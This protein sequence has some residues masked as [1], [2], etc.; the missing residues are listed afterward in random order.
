MNKSRIVNSNKS[1]SQPKYI[2]E[3]SKY[4]INIDKFD[5]KLSFEAENGLF[6]YVY[7]Y[8]LFLPTKFEMDTSF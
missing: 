1:Q 2:F 4:Y 8:D 3:F 6:M 5:G 7:H